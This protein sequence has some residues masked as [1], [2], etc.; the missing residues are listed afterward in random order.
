[1][2]KVSAK[3]IWKV[4][5]P[6]DGPCGAMRNRPAAMAVG[7]DDRYVSVGAGA[8]TGERHGIPAVVGGLN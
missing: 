3:V 4:N 6:P 5:D 8:P 7:S 1:M 2:T